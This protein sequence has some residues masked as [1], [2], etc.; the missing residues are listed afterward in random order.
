[1]PRYRL[2]C[3]FFSLFSL[4][5]CS[6]EPVKKT[7]QAQVKPLPPVQKPIPAVESLQSSSLED[8]QDTQHLLLAQTQLQSGNYPMA[9][10]QLDDIHYAS[11]SSEQRSRFNLLAAQISLSRA[12]F[13]QALQ[14]LEL[15]RPKLLNSAEQSNYYQSLAF[16]HALAGNILYSVNAR[17][18]LGYL[19]SNP[20]QQQDNMTTM[21][22]AL[23]GLPMFTLDRPPADAEELGGW[24]ALAKIVKQ[25]DQAGFDVPEQ[26]SRWRQAYPQHPA[27]SDFIQNYLYKSAPVLAGQAVSLAVS[28]EA[29]IA[30][31]IPASGTYAA[32][33]KAIKSGILAAQRQAAIT[34][35]QLPL[36]F[37]DSE[38]ADIAGL[39]RQAVAEGAK[40]VIGPLVKEQI[41]ALAETADLN[42]P[43]LALNYVENL[44]KTNL[45]QFGL[46]PQ[47]EA[48]QLVLKARQD[49]RQN[50]VL[51]VPDSVQGQRISHYFSSAW[52]NQG[53][54]VL[55]VQSY[56]PK[57][58]NIAEVLG[59]LLK[60]NVNPQDQS[61]T[62]LLSAGSE[63]ARELAPQ[64]KYHQNLAVYAMPNIYSGHPN[65]VADMEL[66]KINF[67]D[68]PWFFADV[69]KGPLSQLALQ[70]IWQVLPDNQIR[71]MA[72]GID[73]YN[74]LGNLE[75]LHQTVYPGATGHI[76][77]NGEN[78]LTRKLMCAQFKAGAPA[79]LGF[80]E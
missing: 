62:V 75:Q 70:S 60:L 33:G 50:A 6:S 39:Y 22:D 4:I 74:L 11:L 49:G 13:A 5:S 51:L 55:A 3:W 63:A 30:V 59:G 1:M 7:L 24:M 45:Y 72:M 41:Q 79:V 78:R 26:L 14:Q 67:C 80:V 64:L 29:S 57:Q 73:A 66:G 47:D 32:A 40:Q 61:Q 38:Q 20:Q 37:Y 43:V 53:G 58:H 71:L 15:I 36:K 10:K 21:L 56:D 27:S 17:M 42:V 34:A 52:Q 44:S 12:D 2:L 46:S 76:S 69:Y 8:N 68:M 54:V 35:P 16:A 31:L 19:L 28:V 9:S 23:S 65:P 77:L 25:R 18:R 48:E